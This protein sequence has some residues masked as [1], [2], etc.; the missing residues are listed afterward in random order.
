MKKAKSLC[1]GRPFPA[2]VIRCAV[3]WHFRFQLSL[4]DIEALLLERGVVVS[5]ETIASRQGRSQAAFQA[6]ACLL[7]RRAAQNRA[8]PPP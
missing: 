5:Y 1:H 6:R 7:S 3:R 2:A 8:R 4:R